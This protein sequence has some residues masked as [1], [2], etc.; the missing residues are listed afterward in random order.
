MKSMGRSRFD[1]G[2]RAI[3]LEEWGRRCG[4]P[5]KADREARR[6]STKLGE[7]RKHRQGSQTLRWQDMTGD[8]PVVAHENRNSRG[9]S[10]TKA[11]TDRGPA[12]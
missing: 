8:K 4:N 9:S 6:T 7:E 2:E 1:P 11:G 12:E 5:G 3:T 10:P